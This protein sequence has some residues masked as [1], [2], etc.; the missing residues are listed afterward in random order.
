MT[1]RVPH[2]LGGGCT[3][4]VGGGAREGAT[5]AKWKRGAVVT[6]VCLLLWDVAWFQRGVMCFSVM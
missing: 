1:H 3:V 2:A 4:C 6:D 5:R